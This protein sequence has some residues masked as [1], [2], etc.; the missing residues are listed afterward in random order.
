VLFLA[1]PSN[2]DRN[3]Y[4][5]PRS[6]YTE[7]DIQSAWLLVLPGFHLKIG[8]FVVLLA[9]KRFSWRKKGLH[10]EARGPDDSGPNGNGLSE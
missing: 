1:P 8:N 2:T 7:P 5:Q 3:Y 9:Q 10:F 4:H 6:R